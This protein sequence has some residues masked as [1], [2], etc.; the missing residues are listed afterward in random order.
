MN[1]N[2]ILIR[3]SMMSSVV[4]EADV[5]LLDSQHST[6]HQILREPISCL[7]YRNIKAQSYRL[8][9]LMNH[10]F[11]KMPLIQGKFFFYLKFHIFFWSLQPFP[12]HVPPCML[13]QYLD[14]VFSIRHLQVLRNATWAC[15]WKDYSKTKMTT[16]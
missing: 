6:D 14:V 13:T 2:S 7:L 5:L 3:S 9:K 16:A 12:P 15:S 11:H 4:I 10:P 8:L 1:E